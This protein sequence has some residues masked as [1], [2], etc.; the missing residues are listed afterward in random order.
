MFTFSLCF[1]F[2]YDKVLIKWTMKQFKG[3]NMNPIGFID[4]CTTE[5]VRGWA[6]DQDSG[7]KPIYV[8]IYDGPN[9]LGYARADER[10][11]DLIPHIG[12]P[13]HGFKFN[14]PTLSAGKH[15]IYVYGINTPYGS[16]ANA[17]LVHSP[18]TIVVGETPGPGTN[19]KL[20]TFYGKQKFLKMVSLFDT[21]G[22]NKSGNMSDDLDY[23]VD[24][25]ID[26]V[27]LMV[28]WGA[29]RG[30]PC[31]YH[32][33][34]SLYTQKLK[35]FRN[36]VYQAG[37]KGLVADI[38]I[39]SLPTDVDEA[40]FRIGNINLIA[41]LLEWDYD[42]IIL[43]LA[44]EHYQISNGVALAQALRNLGGDKWYHGI[45]IAGGRTP[46]AAWAIVQPEES[47]TFRYHDPRVSGWV[48]NTV[49][50]A[51]SAQA[52]AGD[53][54]VYLD[55]PSRNGWGGQSYRADDFIRACTH[56][57]N[58][59]IAGWCLHNEECFDLRS[60]SF[61]SKLSSITKEAIAG[62]GK[63]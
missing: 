23:L 57:R 5:Y 54:P 43:D 21:E 58:V 36:V 10:R 33:D 40:H 45:S 49:A 22:S 34:G 39:I 11:P 51:R 60:Q 16:G 28:N 46:E 14:L 20:F 18:W 15:H 29:Y 4:E 44:N 32:P 1:Q 12:S 42:H 35:H 9:L 13:D 3:G 25:G 30:E 31:M 56:A 41:K 7:A 55:E 27:R 6:F 48:D 24:S 62:I 8:H 17:Q 50:Y 47:N 61:R 52:C 53:M 19:P 63:L 2:D 26:G 59:G 37:L 38:S